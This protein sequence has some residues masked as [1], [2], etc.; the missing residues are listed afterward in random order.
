[1]W[2]RPR[3]PVDSDAARYSVSVDHEE[4]VSCTDDPVQPKSACS[5][6]GVMF[7]S[8]ALCSCCS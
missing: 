8:Q 7:R 5:E 2:S 6:F 4:L 1:M 3:D